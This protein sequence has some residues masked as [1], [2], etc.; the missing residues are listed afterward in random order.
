MLEELDVIILARDISEQGLSIGDPA[1]AVMVFP[2]G[3][4]TAEFVRPDGSTRALVDLKPAD[5]LKADGS[6]I[7]AVQS[8]CETSQDLA[9]APVDTRP[10]D[11]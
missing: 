9:F 7:S 3:S 10:S 1:T 8:T 2:D 11:A 5:F 6:Q 4:C